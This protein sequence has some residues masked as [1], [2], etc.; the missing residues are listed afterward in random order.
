MVSPRPYR[1]RLTLDQA[2]KEL[3]ENAGTQF[4]PDVVEA[5]IKTVIS[6]EGTKQPD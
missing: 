4:D 6:N 3:S 5:F 2:I 1:E